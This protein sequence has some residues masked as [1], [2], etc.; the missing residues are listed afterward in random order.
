MKKTKNS[1][2]GFVFGTALLGLSAGCVGYVGE[3]GAG[4]YAPPQSV[5]VESGVAAQDD[6][7]YYPAYQVY[8]SGYRHQYVYLDGHSWV[9]R[10]APPRVSAD[11]V[12]ASPSVKVDFHDSPANHNAEIV[13]QYPKH[14]TPSQENRDNNEDIQNGDKARQDVGRTSVIKKPSEQNA[15]RQPVRQEKPVPAASEKN[16]GDKAD[17]SHDDKS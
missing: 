17:K 3:P 9:S 16:G 12:F 15:A 6:Y 13:K 2:I 4:V 8:Y 10:S 14:W 7:V 5:Y 1:T 11:V